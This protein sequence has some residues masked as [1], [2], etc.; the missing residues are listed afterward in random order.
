MKTVILIKEIY[1]EGF[2]NI[3]NYL[4]KHALK[5]LTWFTFAMFAIV[6]YAFVFR[7][8]TGFSFSNI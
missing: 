7:L 1:V 3:G 8:V 2:R 5:I 6:L 4:S